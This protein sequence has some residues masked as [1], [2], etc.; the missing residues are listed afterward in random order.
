MKKILLAMFLGTSLM[1][2]GCPASLQVH[3]TPTA[4]DIKNDPVKVIQ[5]AIDQGNANVAAYGSTV[6]KYRKDKLISFQTKEHYT[7]ILEV[8]RDNIKKAEK[9]LEIG[10]L[11]EA[12]LRQALF[13]KGLDYIKGELAKLAAE[14]A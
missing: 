10:D 8:A 13:E 14:E 2:A 9:A 5:N 1:L 7:D 6:L 11:A 3:P 12:E 4:E